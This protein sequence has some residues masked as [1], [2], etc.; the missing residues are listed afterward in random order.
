MEVQLHLLTTALSEILLRITPFSIVPLFMVLTLL[1]YNN[2]TRHM[3]QNYIV[4]LLVSY[5]TLHSI[6]ELQHVHSVYTMYS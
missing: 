5:S 6:Y 4:L 2:I 1:A 3:A